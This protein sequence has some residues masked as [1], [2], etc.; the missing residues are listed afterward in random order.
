MPV[1]L[2]ARDIFRAD[3]AVRAGLVLDDDALPQQRLE[4][5]RKEARD[6]IGRSAGR[7]RDHDAHGPRGEILG[8]A[9]AAATRRCGAGRVKGHAA[10]CRRQITS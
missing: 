2:A 6:E 5:V 1:R 9:T 7:E 3:R 8:A 4:L 10:R